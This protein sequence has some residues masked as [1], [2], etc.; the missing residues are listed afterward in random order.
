MKRNMIAGLSILAVVAGV[1]WKLASNA[2]ASTGLQD[3]SLSQH[4]EHSHPGSTTD[5][6]M[7]D[8]DT[9][10]ASDVSSADT[11]ASPSDSF[12]IVDTFSAPD[13]ASAADTLSAPERGGQ[14]NI[15]PSHSYAHCT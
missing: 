15:V 11:H 10:A 4:S 3:I 1:G 6:G 14:P 9:N 2:E 5:S 12:T 13:T 8:D 7:R